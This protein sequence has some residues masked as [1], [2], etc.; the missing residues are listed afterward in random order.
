MAD[1]QI[2]EQLTVEEAFLVEGRRPF[3]VTAE[4]GEAPRVWD[5]ITGHSVGEAQLAELGL[6]EAE[7]L[8]D[9]SAL[10]TV[11]NRVVAVTLGYQTE[12]RRQLV[13]RALLSTSACRRTVRSDGGRPPPKEHVSARVRVLGGGA[14]AEPPKQHRLVRPLRFS[15]TRR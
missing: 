4:E 8:S 15:T 9:V 1:R 11:C 3:A 14:G 2:G 7:H 13:N 10:T 12:P 5:L 6:S